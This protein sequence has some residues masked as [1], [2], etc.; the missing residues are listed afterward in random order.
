MV[1]AIGAQ[2]RHEG[3]G[4]LRLPNHFGKRLGPVAAVESGGHL[5]I[6][7]RVHDKPADIKGLLAHPPEP[8]YPCYVSVLGE[9]AW[10][11]PR[12]EPVTS[13]KHKAECS[14]REFVCTQKCG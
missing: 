4:D 9:L 12:E 10:M 7:E 14:P 2:R 11:A 3:V 5:S 1:D 6:V 13:V 8:G